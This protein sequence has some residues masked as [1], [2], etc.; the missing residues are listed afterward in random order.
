MSVGQAGDIHKWIR[1][2][3]RFVLGC[4]FALS[5]LTDNKNGAYSRYLTQLIKARGN[6]MPKML[7]VQADSTQRYADGTAGQTELDKTILRTLWGGR[8]TTASA[9]PAAVELA[10]MAGEGFDVVTLM[11]TLHY[12]FK[13]VA[14]LNGFLRN[15]SESLKVGGYF[16]GCCFDGDK[17]VSMLD[18]IPTGSAKRGTDGSS[19]IW[20]ITK[21]YDS[22]MHTLPSDETGLGKPIDVGFISIGEA[23]TEYLVSW[24]YFERRMNEIGLELLN[25]DEL[26]T[27]GLQHSTNL[28]SASYDMAVASGK[29]FPM[30]ASMK[31]FSFLNRWFIFR[32]RT[33]G[34]MSYAENLATAPVVLDRIEPR[35]SN[36]M[37]T[38]LAP[39][40]APIATPAPS[41]ASIEPAVAEEADE[42]D[43]ADVVEEMPASVPGLKLATG[44]AYAFYHKSA[45]K[46]DLKIKDRQWK[47][48]ISTF[49]PFVFKDTVNPSVTYT[50]LEAVLGAAKYQT[51]TNKQ[52][53]GAQIFGSLGNIHQA[54][55]EEK[56]SLTGGTRPLTAEEEASFVEKEG[57]MYRNAQKLTEMK[58]TG[59]KF[60]GESWASNIDSVLHN[61]LR[62][63]FEGDVHFRDILQGVERQSAKLV[64][65]MAGGGNELSGTLKEDGSIEGM[66]VYGKA[67]MKLVGLK[68]E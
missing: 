23:K 65:Y 1:S 51:A 14:T 6:P 61:Y 7:F 25:A 57:T 38:T 30:S 37:S 34:S 31:T 43:E 40:P 41:D 3:V 2:K 29:T 19:D 53:L 4:D 64:Y 60:V 12:F 68:Y 21:K 36:T 50:S 9:P 67:L 52:E 44:P 20:T 45:P 47:R 15:V 22:S 32:R 58:K 13:D 56:R 59:A 66:N 49:A 63:R 62:Q 17:V 27:L 8:E 39:L 46:D 35:V 48:Y 5:G 54:I 28:F 18:D 33:T 24:P 16:V 55:L 42:A 11:F 26:V 10:G